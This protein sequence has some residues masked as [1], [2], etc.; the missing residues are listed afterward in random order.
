M[1]ALENKEHY[2]KFTDEKERVK[3]INRL[4]MRELSIFYILVILFSYYELSQGYSKTISILVI[5][6]SIVFGILNTGLYI[7]NK[8]ARKYSYISLVLYFITF[9][10]VLVFE[11]IQLMLFTSIVVLAALIGY[12]SINL[13][14]QFSVASVF[15]GVF[16]CIYH[17]PLNHES[18]V[19]PI[20]MLGTL[21]IYI[22]AVLAIYFTTLRSIQFNKA[23]VSKIE[24]E[25]NAQANILN[26]II[27]IT[28]TVKED[29]DA[30]YDPVHDLG[31][32]T[33]TT[34][35]S[36]NE[37]SV[38]TQSI[39]NS[40]QEQTIM[41]QSIQKAIDET[42]G[43]SDKMKQFA[44]ESNKSIMEC[45]NLMN[46][47]REHSAGIA[48]FNANVD[49]SMNQLSEKTQS[50]QNIAGI[51][52]GISNQTNLLALNASIEA[53]RAGEAGKGF[54]VVAGEIRKLSDEVKK[55]IDSINQTIDEL[56]EQVMLVT[57]NVRQ[58]IDTANKQGNM[59]NSSVDIFN[60]INGNV[61]SLLDIIEKVRES[62]NELQSSNTKIV[63]NISQI[64]ATTEEVSASSEEAAGISETNYKNLEDVIRLLKDIEDTFSRLNKYI[65]A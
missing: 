33:K 11:D 30:S 1:E 61:D 13:I 60:N 47:I 36:V 16:N 8:D 31:E 34:N 41:T 50:V 23:S 49:K 65:N 17:I 22:A 58:S 27:H 45:F 51:I 42:A 25:K 32:S 46:Q 35:N 38:S 64:S 43:L 29:V 59:I 55:S 56:N 52:S 20:T 19:P 24:D 10:N 21:L 54:A 3:I 7:K 26:D 18:S 62:I 6:S 9:F 57:N 14:I 12:F 2:G 53:A 63:D 4:L 44:D 28:K 39:A 40:I 15:V 5:I 48:L 37:I